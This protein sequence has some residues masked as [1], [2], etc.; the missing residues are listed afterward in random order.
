MLILDSRSRAIYYF[1]FRIV[2]PTFPCGH[3]CPTISV[4]VFG[5]RDLEEFFSLDLTHGPA[6]YD[7]CSVDLICRRFPRTHFA[8]AKIKDI[9]WSG[10]TLERNLRP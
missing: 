1:R 2:L 8:S 7:L 9:Y 6:C 10:A 5:R 4:F 3:L